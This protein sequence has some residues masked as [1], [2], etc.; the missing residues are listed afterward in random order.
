MRNK[1]YFYKETWKTDKIKFLMLCNKCELE[2]IKFA[3]VNNK[4]YIC[5]IIITDKL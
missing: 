2:V 5:R 4:P 3:Q 1:E